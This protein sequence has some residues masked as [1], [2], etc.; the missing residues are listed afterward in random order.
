M[1]R[2]PY[3]RSNKTLPE[4]HRRWKILS[5][6][7]AGGSLCHSSG[8]WRGES[9]ASKWCPSVSVALTQV[10]SKWQIEI[11]PGQFSVLVA[12]HLYL[13]YLLTHML[14]PGM[15]REVVQDGIFCGSNKVQKRQKD[16]S[17]SKLLFLFWAW[18]FFPLS[19]IQFV[20][21][22]MAPVL[23]NYFSHNRG[24][25]PTV[26]QITYL[27]GDVCE[28]RA[29]VTWAGSLHRHCLLL[30]GRGSSGSLKWCVYLFFTSPLH[31]ERRLDVIPEMALLMSS[32]SEF[33]G[34][35]VA[36]AKARLSFSFGSP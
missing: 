3:F 6:L 11:T 19:L 35:I 2:I 13:F 30:S 17:F 31:L 29:L 23:V 36:K 16:V 5:L 28:R 7:L 21:Q 14:V 12:V 18:D 22:K 9:P 15:G 32:S 10:M 33:L 24:V 20:W 34:H 25:V 8:P 4:S 27:P 1:P 26:L